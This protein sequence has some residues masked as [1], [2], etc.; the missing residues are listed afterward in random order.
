MIAYVLTRTAGRPKMFA[1]LR[2]SLLSQDFPGRVFHLVHAETGSD[3]AEADIVIEGPHLP[4]SFGTAP[5]ELHNRTLLEHLAT[6]VRGTQDREPTHPEGWVTFI[7]DD[8]EYVSQHSLAR[9]LQHAS[10]DVMPIW[11]VQRAHHRTQEPI[12]SPR[13]W[14]GDLSS[15]YGRLCWEAAA[16]HTKWI[17]TAK[18]DADDGS[19]GR[20]WHQLSQHLTL[21]WQDEVLTRP[22]VGKGKGKRRDY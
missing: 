18:I 7:D 21:A 17:G 3:Y 22:Q 6:L 13:D 1:R 20:Y 14:E 10:P 9:M 2:E 12:L 19:D 11:R 16:H 15:H 8:D 5:W 4:R